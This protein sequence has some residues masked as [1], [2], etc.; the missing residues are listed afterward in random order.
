MGGV[1]GYP[2]A[3]AGG[4][5]GFRPFLAV[6]ADGAAAGY[7]CAVQGGEGFVRGDLDHLDLA[8]AFAV[9]WA[10]VM[11]VARIRLGG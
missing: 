6:G 10:A 7:L 4:S 8:G 3:G 5:A 2:L 1:V 11:A 9:E